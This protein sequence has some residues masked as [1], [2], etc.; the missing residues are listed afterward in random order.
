MLFSP[1]TIDALI[2]LVELKLSYLNVTDREDRAELRVLQIALAE[3]EA[4]RGRPSA[5]RGDSIALH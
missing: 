5:V 4:G 3:L 2:E 1:G